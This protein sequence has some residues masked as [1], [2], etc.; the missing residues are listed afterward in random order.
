VVTHSTRRHA[1][2]IIAL[3]LAVGTVVGMQAA[4]NVAHAKETINPV[5]GCGEDSFLDGA[6]SPDP[7]NTVT[8]PVGATQ[9]FSVVYHDESPINMSAGFAPL[10]TVTDSAGHVVQSGAPATAPASAPNGTKDKFNTLVSVVYGPSAPGTYTLRIKAWDGDQNKQGG[11]CGVALWTLNTPAPPTTTTIPHTTTT[12]PHTTTTKPGDT[13]TTTQPSTPQTNVLG[14]TFEQA[15][16][17]G[18][19]EGTP[20]LTG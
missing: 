18:A 13:T 8:V 19:V 20:A 11:D 4:N 3:S 12:V 14:E 5:T 15:P 7:G 10:Y 17:A 9:A 6:V 1:G 16:T 2:R